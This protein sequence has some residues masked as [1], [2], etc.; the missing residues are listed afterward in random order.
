MADVTNAAIVIAIFVVLF[1]VRIAVR[2]AFSDQVGKYAD[3][4]VWIYVVVAAGMIVWAVLDAIGVIHES[5]YR[6]LK[7]Y[8]Y[9]TVS[10]IVLI[11]L[12]IQARSKTG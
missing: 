3:D 12:A 7:T 11:V 5:P 9:A 10:A 4:H 2:Q 1:G 6:T 8:I